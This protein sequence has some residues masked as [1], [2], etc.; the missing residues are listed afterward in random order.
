MSTLII[1]HTPG[2]SLTYED[3]DIVDILPAAKNPGAAVTANPTGSF[4]FV[5][6]TDKEPD[7]PEVL[8]LREPL[9]EGEEQTKKRAHAANLPGWPSGAY[10]TYLP[11]ADATAQ[12]TMTWQVFQAKVQHK[13][14]G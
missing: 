4:S 10:S 14:N 11:L 5:Y 12:Q 13:G 2:G 7:D 6:V 8:A 3:G 1:L 9:A